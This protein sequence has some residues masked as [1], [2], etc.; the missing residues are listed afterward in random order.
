MSSE[1]SVQWTCERCTATTVTGHGK[2]PGLWHR[3]D[4]AN[5][6]HHAEPVSQGDICSDCWDAFC[7]WWRTP[8][9]VAPAV[10]YEEEET[11]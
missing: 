11:P 7:E 9:T 1:I 5:P 10:V 3:I 8:Q 2:Q 4:A 6:P